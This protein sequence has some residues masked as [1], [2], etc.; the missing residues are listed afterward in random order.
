MFLLLPSSELL[1]EALVVFEDQAQVVDLIFAHRQTL[2][3]HAEGP[4]RVHVRVDAAAGEHLRVD[5]AGA[6]HLAISL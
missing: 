1:E 4:A 3:A 5:H 2:E 6:E